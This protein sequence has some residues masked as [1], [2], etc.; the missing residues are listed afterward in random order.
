MAL[1]YFDINHAIEV[2]DAII[3]QSGGLMGIAKQGQLDSIISFIQ[4]DDYYP[5]FI[6]KVTFLFYGINTGH[7]FVDGNKRASIAL[8]AYFLEINNL[9]CIVP[10]FI[11]S[12]ENIA[13]YVAA[14]KIDRDLLYEILASII[15]EEYYSEELKLKIFN[16][17]S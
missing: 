11:A 14:N 10:K 2:H 8:T 6:D 4:H 12:M 15:Y 1:I 7:C 3:I 17:L 13:V 5:E 16:A 9:G